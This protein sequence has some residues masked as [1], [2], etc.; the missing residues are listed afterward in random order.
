MIQFHAKQN[1]HRK[2]KKAQVAI[3]YLMSYGWALLIILAVIAILI[4]SG[5]WKRPAPS[6][7]FV[8][9]D[10]PCEAAAI[11]QHGGDVK[12]IFKFRN[13]QGGN[14]SI[15]TPSSMEIIEGS[16]MELQDSDCFNA[17]TGYPS[18]N[19]GEEGECT[20]DYRTQ[21]NV[22]GENMK[23]RFTLTYT[24]E[25]GVS[26]TTSGHVRATVIPG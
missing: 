13:N 26:H 15:A 2:Q 19:Q 7:C 8:H 21:E 23:I 17:D 6:E 24:D 1:K 20:A 16:H 25:M 18:I 12:L 10:L 22:V 5:I 4:G 14:I 3:E 11:T 9:P